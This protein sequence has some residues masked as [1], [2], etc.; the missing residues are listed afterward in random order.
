MWQE[1]SLVHRTSMTDSTPLEVSGPRWKTCLR[2]LLFLDPGSSVK[3]IDSEIRNGHLAHRFLVEVCSGLHSPLFGETEVFGQFRSFREN[4]T[5]HPA[6]ENL[7][8]AV[9]EDV[10]RL[11][12]SH[13]VG[14]GSQSYGSLARRHLPESQPVIL[15]GG[16]RLAQDLIPW[17]NPSSLT[18]VLRNPDRWTCRHPEVA[19]VRSMD[20][21]LGDTA[22]FGASWLLAAPLAN[23]LLKKMWACTAP[24]V[25]LD[26]RGETQLSEFPSGCEKYL[27]LRAIYEELASVRLLHEKKRQEALEFARELTERR[28]TRWEQGVIHRPFGWEDA[29]S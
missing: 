22:P 18:V 29:C 21:I 6:W 2:E 14:I 19:H 3:Q 24:R 16:G 9:E 12:R 15:I 17:I 10:R 11:R 25:V 27:S 13:L 7:L 26:F 28:L 8:D 20:S 5:W 1:L 23:D 4:H